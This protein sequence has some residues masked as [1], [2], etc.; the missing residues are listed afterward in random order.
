LIDNPSSYF[1]SFTYAYFPLSKLL[2]HQ[3]AKELK[4]S[5]TV[6]KPENRK[7]F[8]AAIKEYMASLTYDGWISFNSDFTKINRREAASMEELRRAER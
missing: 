8:M 5:L 6:V 4:K 7:A 1:F 3:N 2:Y